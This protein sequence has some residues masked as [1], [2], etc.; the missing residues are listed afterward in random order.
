MPP[1]FEARCCASVGRSSTPK[2]LREN[3]WFSDFSVLYFV[4]NKEVPGPSR[5]KRQ[6]TNIGRK[7]P[8]TEKELEEIANAIGDDSGSD[9]ELSELD[10][11]SEI[12]DSDYDNGDSADTKTQDNNPNP[13][14]VTSDMPAWTDTED[15]KNIPFIGEPGLLVPIP[16][17]LPYDFFSLL[18]T[19]DF[20]MHIVEETN[21]YAEVLF[22]S[23]NTKAK[24]RITTWKPVDLPEFKV[25]L[26]LWLHM[27]NIQINRIQD[28]WKTDD[29]FNLPFFAK[30]M[31]RNR[32]L[33]ILRCLHFDR[34]PLPGDEGFGDRLHK[35]RFM[36]EY[37]NT[38]MFE[39][40]YPQKN[41]SLDES[42]IL[43]RG[44]LV[45]RQYIKG[46]KHKYGMKLYILAEPNG[47]VLRVRL[48]TGA[49]GDLGGKNHAENVVLSLVRGLE[50]NGHALYMDNFY[51]SYALCQTLLEKKIYVTGT[52]RKDR[53][54]NPKDVVNAKL[55]KGEVT[56]KYCNGV[57]V[58]KWHDKRDVLFLSTEFQ[59]EMV[60]VTTRRGD[61]MEKPLA[62]V[63]YNENMSGI[64]KQDQMLAYYPSERKTLRWYKKLAIHFLSMLLIN[65]HSLYNTHSTKKISLYDFRLAVIKRLLSEQPPKQL[66]SE[67]TL[68][69]T[70][71]H[72]PE[73][74]AVVGGK[75]LRKRCKVCYSKKIRK[76]TPYCCP[77]CPDSPGLC[78]GDCFREYHRNK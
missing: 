44:R 52:L 68:P 14:S 30:H 7:K 12:S 49:G 29:L 36:Q 42:M 75:Q 62:I 10:S 21:E 37:F 74:Y 28:Y 19:D 24:S 11:L 18:V 34:N 1:A 35:I 69:K 54:S 51:N 57:A 50:G 15:M 27:G 40:Y 16:A 32:F 22:L 6:S 26:G 65:S 25:F 64:D 31:S 58:S 63:K 41:L 43:W 70:A 67:R 77:V 2:F 4:M 17:N 48:Y 9:F 3:F 47:L 20:L 55:K 73:K 23:E 66:H 5:P 8:L 59:Q 33:L 76:D 78:L 45:F 72:C 56:T 13:S 60:E 53:K 61:V 71:E 38:K 39:L 46:K